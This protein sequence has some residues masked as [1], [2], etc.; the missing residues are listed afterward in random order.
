MAPCPAL[1]DEKAISWYHVLKAVQTEA[2]AEGCLFLAYL[3]GI[4][5]RHMTSIGLASDNDRT[6]RS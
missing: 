5:L 3:V 4:A 6:G 2:R 1:Q